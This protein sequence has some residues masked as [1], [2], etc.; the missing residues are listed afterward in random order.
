MDLEEKTHQSATRIVD[1]LPS[2]VIEYE[3]T[4]RR[5]NRRI[6]GSYIPTRWRRKRMWLFIC[7]SRGSAVRDITTLVGLWL[8]RIPLRSRWLRCSEVSLCIE[9][10]LR[11]LLL[12]LLLPLLLLLLLLRLLLL[13]RRSGIRLPH[14]TMPSTT[15][16]QLSNCI[17]WS[18]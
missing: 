12:R 7:R 10:C 16:I 8:R 13:G 14:G 4:Q 1:C 11:L 5:R 9:S 15:N 3:H 6:S 2:A 18:G 17:C